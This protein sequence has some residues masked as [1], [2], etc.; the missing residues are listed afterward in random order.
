M[1]AAHEADDAN[2]LLPAHHLSDLACKLDGGLVRLGARVADEDAGGGMEGTGLLGAFDQQLRERAG[3]GVVVEVADVDQLLGLLIDELA[4]AVIVVA[5]SVDGD[6]GVEVNVPVVLNVEEVASVA[7]DE[8]GKRA[9]IG[10]HHVGKVL[11]HQGGALRVGS[12]IGVGIARRLLLGVSD[13]NCEQFSRKHTAI[14]AFLSRG[15]LKAE[16]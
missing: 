14:P 2:L 15:R 5:E 4:E 16:A 7:L 9:R 6:A 13:V 8:D 12:R 11:G 3:P 1:E 10:G